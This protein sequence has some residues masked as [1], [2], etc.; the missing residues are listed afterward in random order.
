VLN[1]DSSPLPAPLR[2]ARPGMGEVRWGRG[3]LSRTH[4]KI[5]LNQDATILFTSGSSS[6]PKAALHSF[7]NHY[8]NALA[9]N[10]W[11]PLKRGDRWLLSLPLVHVSGLGILFRVLLAG[12]TIVLPEKKEPLAKSLQKYQISHVSLVPTQLY[13]LLQNTKSRFP[14]LKAILLGGAPIPENLLRQSI[15]QK[16]PVHVTYGLTEMAS[17]VATSKEINKTNNKMQARILKH[18]RIKIS[19]GKEIWVKGKTLFKGYVEGKKI[20]SP[21]NKQGWFPTGDLGIL[22]KNKILKILG[23]KDNMFIS[24]GENIQPEEIEACLYQI[25][26]IENALVVPRQNQEFGFRPVAFIQ[27]KTKKKM[28]KEYLKNYLKKFL[29]RFKIPVEF[30]PWPWKDRTRRESLK[31]NRREFYLPCK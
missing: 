3:I 18:A 20:S 27:F 1:K 10:G 29:P 22:E 25:R 11:I 26:G 14:A 5:N 30:Y 4:T 23:R 16:L 2:G 7:G 17:Q 13:R 8:Y 21:L 24:G 6:Q 12:A 19:S 31:I 28:T 15:K 9:A